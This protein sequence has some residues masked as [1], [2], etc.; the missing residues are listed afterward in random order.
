VSEVAVTLTVMVLG[1]V[2]TPELGEVWSQLPPVP[3]ATASKA[4]LRAVPVL[5]A[6][7]FCEGGFDPPSVILKLNGL[8]GLKTLVPTTTLTGIVT[9]LPEAWKTT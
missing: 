2:C 3:V 8:T 9:L 1:V 5:A 7:K 6:V 4:K